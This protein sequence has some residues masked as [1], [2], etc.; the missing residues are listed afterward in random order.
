MEEA[1]SGREF[2]ILTSFACRNFYIVYKYNTQRRLFAE[3][4][5]IFSNIPVT[6]LRGFRIFEE[7]DMPVMRLRNFRLIHAWRECSCDPFSAQT[8][9]KI[10]FCSLLQP[11][12]NADG[13]IDRTRLLHFSIMLVIVVGKCEQYGQPNIAQCYVFNRRPIVFSCVKYVNSGKFYGVSC[14]GPKSSLQ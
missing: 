1:K 12:V 3:F 14:C 2:I 10:S 9:E 13:K 4:L 11:P 5:S 8:L 7:P 6:S